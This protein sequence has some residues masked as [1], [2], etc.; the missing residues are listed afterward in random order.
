VLYRQLKV[1]AGV[2]A[3][4]DGALLLL[5]RSQKSD[6][7]PRS[8][9]LPAG[10]CEAD[11]SPRVTAVRE[12]AEETSLQVEAGQL[13]DAY[14][15][16]DDPRGNGLLLVYE[17]EIV[18]GELAPD[19]AEAVEA[20]FFSPGQLP[21]PL[22]GGGHDQAI[23]A[24]QSRFRARWQPGS[25]MLFCPHCTQPLETNLAFDR[26]RPVCPA[27]G[28]V[29]FRAP[30]VGVSVL[31]E[32]GDRLLLVR[33]AVEPEQGKWSLPSGFVEWDESPEAAAVRE[34]AEETGLVLTGLSL[35]E[36]RHYSDDFRGPGINLTYRGQVAG[37]ALRPGD[38]AADAQFLA[39]GELPP[40]EQIAF[41]GH[42]LMLK[43]WQEQSLGR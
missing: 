43:R 21:S 30:K 12:A 33:R 23:L 18:G 39:A 3:Q 10:Y 25:P 27:C 8:W 28:F 35:V 40:A 42:R 29:H 9:S 32:E 4:R 41:Q 15:F 16:D 19:G 2:L 7:F 36:V 17:A 22:C 1:G 26:V 6:A 5:R 34:C 13:V 38:D 14:F 31:I 20:G 24:W 37:G 11:E